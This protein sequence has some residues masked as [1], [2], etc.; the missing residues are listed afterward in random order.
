MIVQWFLGVALGIWKWMTGRFPVDPASSITFH[1]TDLFT[2]WATGIQSTG[3]WFPWLILS[4]CL[5]TVGAFYMGALT[6]RL[7]RAI[8]GYIPFIGGNG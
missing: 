7:I 2:P 4:E 6:L 8:V 3:V 5:I 1:M